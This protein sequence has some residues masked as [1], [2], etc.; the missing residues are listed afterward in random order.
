MKKGL[1]D[2]S[3][4]KMFIAT[5]WRKKLFV[6]TLDFEFSKKPTSKQFLQAVVSCL[7]TY[8]AGDLSRLLMEGQN[9]EEKKKPQH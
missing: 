6:A 5:E 7:E 4:V 9:K 8:G 3:I 1:K 2:K